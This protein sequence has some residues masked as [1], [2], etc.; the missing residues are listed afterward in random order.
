M[1]DETRL[2]DALA[3]IGTNP[4]ARRVLLDAMLQVER[5]LARIDY[6]VREEVTGPIVDAMHRDCGTLSVTLDNGVVYTYP[7]ISGLAREIA[8][9]PEERP[10]YVWEP[11]TTRTLL[12]LA[13]G[14]RHVVVGGA[15]GG[16]Q[17]VLIAHSL[18]DAGGTVHCFEPNPVQ[19]A[20]LLANIENNGLD[21]VR[22]DPR[23]V[24]RT[25]EANLVL[26]GE[27]SHAHA[28][29]ADAAADDAFP[30][31]RIATYCAEAGVERIDLLMLDIEGSEHPALEGAEPFLDMDA[32]TAPVVVFEIHSKYTDWSKGLGATPIVSLLERH[33]YTVLALRDMQGASPDYHPPVE[34]IPADAVY[35]EGPHHGFNMLAVKDASVLDD[36]FFRIVRGVSPKYLRHRTPKLHAPLPR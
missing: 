22:V 14:A 11:Q 35:L 19:R 30:T 13:K 15:Y 10:D 17:A 16:D 3:A 34:I 24:W 27:D 32:D 36:G 31:V 29:E 21:N 8:M 7:Y 5:K 33:G 18:K 9:N 12:H 23:G 20:T 4:E 28:E 2:Q 6:H 26:V 1:N 25:D